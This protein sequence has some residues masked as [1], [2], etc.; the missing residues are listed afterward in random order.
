MTSQVLSIL[1]LKKEQISL[2]A[3][4]FM[5]LG[6][7][8]KE[9]SGFTKSCRFSSSCYG[10]T[11]IPG[12]LEHKHWPNGTCQLLKPVAWHPQK[13]THVFCINIEG[14]SVSN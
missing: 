10:P 1:G 6:S 2:E 3:Q 12:E 8:L 4:F 13:S 14:G 11:L 9:A 5:Y 7:H